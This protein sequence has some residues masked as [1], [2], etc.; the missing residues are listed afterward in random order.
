VGNLVTTPEQDVEVD[1]GDI[2]IWPGQPQYCYLPVYDP[3]LVFFGSGGIFGGSMV[4]FSA[5]LPIGVWLNYDFDWHRRRIYYHGW[6]DGP[7]WINR[8]RPY[9]HINSVY[10]NDNL[11]HLTVNRSVTTLVVNYGDLARYNSVHQDVE[12]GSTRINAG[13]SGAAPPNNVDNKI[14]QRI[15]NVDD[16]RTDLNRG[17]APDQPVAGQPEPNR[18]GNRGSFDAKVSSQRGQSSRAQA[19][20]SAPGARSSGGG[21]SHGGGGGRHR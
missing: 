4:T 9:I 1:D 16:G 12:Y 3:S 13:V 20:H 5:R 6:A 7:G 17:R 18:G 11:R 10:V 15:S 8:S 2:E 14:S 19:T 21:S